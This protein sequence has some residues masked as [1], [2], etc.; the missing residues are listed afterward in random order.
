VPKRC[1]GDI[2][3]RIALKPCRSDDK[4]RSGRTSLTSCV[5][6]HVL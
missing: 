1:C 4:R 6:A 3:R 5:T 2:S